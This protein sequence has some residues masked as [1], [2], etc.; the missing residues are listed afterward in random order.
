MVTYTLLIRMFNVHIQTNFSCD[1]V[2]KIS[3]NIVRVMKWRRRRW[4][5]RVLRTADSRCA[6]RVVVGKYV[7]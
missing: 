7:G 4:A 6:Y 3:S 5:G 1:M 2:S